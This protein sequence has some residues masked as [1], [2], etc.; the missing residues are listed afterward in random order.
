[1]AGKMAL[2]AFREADAENRPFNTNYYN[3]EVHRAAFAVPEF[4]RKGL[5]TL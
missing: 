5:T 2:S 3:A 4:L 1:M